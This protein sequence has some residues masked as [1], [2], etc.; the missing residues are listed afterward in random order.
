MIGVIYTNLTWLC[1][2]LCTVRGDQA[3]VIS[4]LESDLALMYRR[5]KDELEAVTLQPEGVVSR[6]AVLAERCA[7]QE[8]VVGKCGGLQ[9]VTV[10]STTSL[11]VC[12]YVWHW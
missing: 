2:S 3:T 7:Q 8:A 6:C 9:P 4:R 1:I 11:S 10:V 12:V 5:H